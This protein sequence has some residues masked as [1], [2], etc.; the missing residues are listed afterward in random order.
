MVWFGYQDVY[1]RISIDYSTGLG[2]R[3]VKGMKYY[4]A[5]D[6]STGGTNIFEGYAPY[7][8]T[9]FNFNIG[10]KVGYHF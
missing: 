5:D 8:Q 7:K 2:I 3:N 6:Y 1:D 10:I 4:L 9:L